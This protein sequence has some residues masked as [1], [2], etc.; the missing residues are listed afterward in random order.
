MPLQFWGRI[1]G[2][3]QKIVNYL[4]FRKLLEVFNLLIGFQMKKC[5]WLMIYIDFLLLI[6]LETF[7]NSLTNRIIFES[8]YCKNYYALLLLLFKFFIVL[9][10]YGNLT[11]QLLVACL[12]RYRRTV[13]SATAAV[14]FA[15]LVNGNHSQ[16]CSI[17]QQIQKAE[18]L[19][20][21]SHGPPLLQKISQSSWSLYVLPILRTA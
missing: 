20:S 4:E 2:K 18:V 7:G 1:L 21:I 5:E 16:H 13:W 14:F 15:I 10:K 12:Q 9:I 11:L 17:G 8:N 3:C 6:K 19:L